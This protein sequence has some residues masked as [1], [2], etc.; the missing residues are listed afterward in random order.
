MHELGAVC[1]QWSCRWLRRR[2]WCSV[3]AQVRS[4]ATFAALSMLISSLERPG[5]LPEPGART[6]A[7]E[8]IRD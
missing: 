1:E 6:G 2:D 8:L 5:G 4:G 7:P 3:L